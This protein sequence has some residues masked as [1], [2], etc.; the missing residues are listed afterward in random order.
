MKESPRDTDE[1]KTGVVLRCSGIAR[2][3]V[4]HM[5]PGF[6]R[7]SCG[8]LLP[9]FLFGCR[10]IF[11]TPPGMLSVPDSRARILPPDSPDGYKL[12]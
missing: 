1:L 6:C 4:V 2:A 11:G 12:S 7:P 9:L 3:P 10:K 8:D 5:D